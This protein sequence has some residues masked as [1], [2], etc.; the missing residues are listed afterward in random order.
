MVVLA[1]TNNDL[2]NSLILATD[3]RVYMSTSGLTIVPAVADS[4]VVDGQTLN[5][6]DVKPLRPAGVTILYDIQA[7]TA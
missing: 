2:K 4:I 1:Y 7:R 6:I 3:K 5:V